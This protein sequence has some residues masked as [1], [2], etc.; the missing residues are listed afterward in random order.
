[1]KTISVVMA[2]I[3]IAGAAW[4]DDELSLVETVAGPDSKV[5]GLA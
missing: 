1:M 3:L 5:G 2:I 4:A